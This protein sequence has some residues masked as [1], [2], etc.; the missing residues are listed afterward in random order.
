M[1]PLASEHIDKIPYVAIVDYKMGNLHS[2]ANACSAIGLKHIITSDPTLILRSSALIIPGVGAFGDAISN[3]TSLDLIVPI[4][5]FITSGRPVMGI[6]LGLQLL[7]TK[8]HEF[9]IWKGLDIIQGEVVSFPSINRHG[10]KIRIPSVGWNSI[11]QNKIPWQNTA[12]QNITSGEDMYFIHSFLVQPTDS[13]VILSKTVYEDFEYCSSILKDNVLALQF[14]P[15]KSGSSGIEI[16][17]SWAKM[18]TRN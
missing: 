1:S 17:R 9:G 5:D 8:S 3:L 18:I 11:Q 13:S 14:H 2:V 15:E 6:C 4:K 7:F 16:Y 12:L 10:K